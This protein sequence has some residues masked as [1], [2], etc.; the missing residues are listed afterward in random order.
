M[1]ALGLHPTRMVAT[2]WRELRVSGTTTMAVGQ[3]ARLGTQALYFVIA[4][5]VLGPAQFGVF[6]TAVALAGV[7]APFA[8]WGAGDMLLQNV[9]RSRQEFAAEWHAALCTIAKFGFV[10]LLITGAVAPWLLPAIP[11]VLIIPVAAAEFW[12]SGLIAAGANAFQAVENFRLAT[13]AWLVLSVARLG[14]AALLAL[15]ID[16][17]DAVAWGMVYVLSSGVAALI[18]SRAVNR[19]LGAPRAGARGA[20]R[21]KGMEFAISLSSASVSAEVGKMALSRFDRLE[22]TGTYAAADR[23]INV[24]SVPILAVLASSYPRL[25]RAGLLG[26]GATLRL[27]APLLAMA[28]LYAA[29]AALIVFFCAPLVEVVLGSGYQQAI[30]ACQILCGLLLL[31]TLTFFAANCLTATNHQRWRSILQIGGACLSAAL[32]FTLVRTHG[33]L[34]AATAALVSEAVLACLLWML[35]A[36]VSARERHAH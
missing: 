34:G 28:M 1:R 11:L 31:R 9:S 8:T 30:A 36:A 20:N 25:H 10:A 24:I 5:R 16:M 35:V 17:P 12:F 7:V 15:V 33:W 29:V 18:I 6:A 26:M 23:I 13:R 19:Q 14:G 27:C 32:A 3:L 21:L 4:A 2:G 22:V